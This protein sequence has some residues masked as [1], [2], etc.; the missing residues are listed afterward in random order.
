[1]TVLSDIKRG[2]NRRKV[3]MKQSR[4]EEDFGAIFHV[5]VPTNMASRVVS[6]SAMVM[7]TIISQTRLKIN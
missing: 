7:F 6:E 5:R 3:T 4:M 2:N 1:M